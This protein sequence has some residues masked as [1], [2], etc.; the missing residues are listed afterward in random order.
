MAKR[1]SNLLPI[2]AL[3]LSA[4]TTARAQEHTAARSPCGTDSDMPFAQIAMGRL[5]ELARDSLVH[6][7]TGASDALQL[8]AALP[9]DVMWRVGDQ[10]LASFVATFSESLGR[11]DAT[12][13]A[14]MF[15]RSGQS[16]WADGIMSIAVHADSGLARRWTQFLEAWVWAG[17]KGAGLGPEASPAEVHRYLVGYRADLSSA[18]RRQLTRLARGEPVPVAR[19]CRLTRGLLLHL[20]VQPP[21]KAGPLIRAMMHGKCVWQPAA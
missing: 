18:A 2:I 9:R 1:L 12:S 7:V 17:V 19:A 5:C 13:C 10:D 21:E 14:S 20:G 16:T 4:A 15:P 6:R 8:M 3:L 11:V